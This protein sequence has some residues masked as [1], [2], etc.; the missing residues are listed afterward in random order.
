MH[1]NKNNMSPER[2]IEQEEVYQARKVTWIGFGVNAVLAVLKILA[3]IVGRSSAMV[4]DGFH[5]MSDFLTDIIVIVF[6]GL[7][8]KKADNH[9]QYGHGKYETFATMIVAFALGAVAIAFLIDGVSAVWGAFHGEVLASPGIIALIMAVL[10]IASKEWLYHYTVGIGRKIN[11]SII[12]A[13]AWHHR[14]DSFSSIAT[15]LGIAGAMYLGPQWRILDPIA[16]I[17]V[18]ALILA[19]A[20]KLARPAIVELLDGA[21]P[22]E[23]IEK[24]NR[25][26]GETEGI[27]AFHRLRSRRNGSTTILEVHLKMDPDMTVEESHRI[28]SE[29]EKK[30]SRE[31]GGKT[32]VTTHIEPYH[33]EDVD[34]NKMCIRKR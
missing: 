5:S 26:I 29:V 8:R 23:V 1:R 31:F 32:I 34:N 14:S 13:N 27:R 17:I 9:Y 24:L 2:N 30:L 15:L 6:V 4:A 7:A 10:S 11:S 18:S 21:L 20:V 25:L 33:G 3:G 19:V 22:E 12:I 28:A 16:A